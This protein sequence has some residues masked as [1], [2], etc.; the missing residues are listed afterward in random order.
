[1]DESCCCCGSGA[2]CWQAFDEYM[3]NEYTSTFL[4]MH[5]DISFRFFITQTCRSWYL[6]VSLNLA[7]GESMATIF[8]HT[9]PKSHME[10]FFR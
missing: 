9:V 3:I 8:K 1:M 4:R 7:S 2:A 5:I 10:Q 6:T